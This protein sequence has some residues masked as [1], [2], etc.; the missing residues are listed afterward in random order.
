M[1]NL[2]S[3][4]LGKNNPDE[5]YYAALTKQRSQR[6]RNVSTTRKN[7]STL[8]KGKNVRRVEMDRQAQPEDKMGAMTDEIPQNECHCSRTQ[9]VR[10]TLSRK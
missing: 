10:Q 3:T 2:R 9:K 4:I 1:R 7:L 6:V 5:I 8:K